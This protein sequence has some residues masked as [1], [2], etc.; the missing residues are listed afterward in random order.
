MII[1]YDGCKTMILESV[2]KDS[3]ITVSNVNSS[4]M[5]RNVLNMIVIDHNIAPSSDSKMG[6]TL[7]VPVNGD[8]QD[9]HVVMDFSK[10]NIVWVRDISE[11]EAAKMGILDKFIAPVQAKFEKLIAEDEQAQTLELNKRVAEEV[12]KLLHEAK[13][14]QP[15]P[16]QA[17]APIAP[18]PQATPMEAMSL[19]PVPAQQMPIQP[20]LPGMSVANM[21]GITSY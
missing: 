10:L 2:I 16:A 11:K 9:G 8:P 3:P 4:I 19:Q 5:A 17:T 1:L 14:T 7:S 15:I 13:A 18:P 20:N 21:S 6:T 12:N